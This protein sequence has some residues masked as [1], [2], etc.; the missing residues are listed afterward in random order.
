MAKKGERAG[1]LD[2]VLLAA[3]EKLHLDPAVLLMY[4]VYDD[5]V[6]LI[7]EDGRKFSVER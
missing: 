3:C 2:P 5:R 1:D 6:V 4:K 7:A